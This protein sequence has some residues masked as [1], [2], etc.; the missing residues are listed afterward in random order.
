MRWPPPDGSLA[1]SGKERSAH[2]KDWIPNTNFN[3]V[4]D[5]YRAAYTAKTRSGLQYQ[6]PSLADA[7]RFSTV[8]M[9]GSSPAH[10]ERML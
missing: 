3:F 9:G 6:F 4:V 7:R 8:L 2:L 10:C 5:R 1:A